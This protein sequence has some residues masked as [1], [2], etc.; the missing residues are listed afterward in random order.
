VTDSLFPDLF[1]ELD[2]AVIEHLDDGRFVLLTTSPAWLDRAFASAPA[3]SQLTLGGAFPF[4][5]D[6]VHQAIGAW[7]AGPH[8]SM[9]F[10]P[11]AATVDGDELLLRATALTMADRMLLVL[12]RLVGVADA[13]PM[14]QKARERMLEGEQLAR[15]V[16]AVHAP[17]A[18]VDRA[19]RAIADED[20]PTRA[21]VEA[22]RDA[23]LKLQASLEGLPKPPSK[24]R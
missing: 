10:G 20:L 13:R 3:G 23:N 9:V 22:L 5:E 2:L 16:A 6:V 4:L 24:R 21:H 12:D 7:Q 17:A 19:V 11:Y 18:A 8:A 14:L 15:R 1:R